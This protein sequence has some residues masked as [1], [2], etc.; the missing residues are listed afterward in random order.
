MKQSIEIPFNTGATDGGM[1]SFFKLYVTPEIERRAAAGTLPDGFEIWRAQV[2]FPDGTT[3][4]IIRLNDEVLGKWKVRGN[5]E[6]SKGQSVNLASFDS[7]EGFE[8]MDHER[9]FGHATFARFSSSWYLAIDFRKNR[10]HAEAL[11]DA[12][13]E[14]LTITRFS[15]G[16]GLSRA[17]WD[18]LFS[19][20]ELV[21]KSYVITV[22]VSRSASRK[23]LQDNI[24]LH[25]KIGNVDAGFVTIFNKAF[26]NRSAARYKGEVLA[27]PDPRA[28]DVIHDVM[29]T[30]K[31]RIRSQF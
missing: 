23:T 20:C 9:D 31:E 26:N 19:C 22:D 13:R 29:E 4:A 5:F 8:L 30:L 7:C 18:N 3:T 1:Q 16:E 10:A 2:L 17:C 25:N 14:F 21:A 28:L 12:A 15:H 6:P 24:N 27:L 11:L